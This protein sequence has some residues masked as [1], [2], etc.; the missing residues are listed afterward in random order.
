MR[1]DPPLMAGFFAPRPPD[2]KPTEPE[3]VEEPTIGDLTDAELIAS[4]KVLR[5]RFDRFVALGFTIPQSRVLTLDKSVD[6]HYARR[7]IQRGCDI[8]LAFDI[9]S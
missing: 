5:H 8:L 3:Q 2:R 7:L 1:I 6:T 4:D 9:L